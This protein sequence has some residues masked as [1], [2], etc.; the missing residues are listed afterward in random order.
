MR[1]SRH[2]AFVRTALGIAVLLAVALPGRAAVDTLTIGTA[3]QVGSASG[4][5]DDAGVAV[6]VPVFLR[7]SS[8]TALN[9]GT[10]A[11]IQ[12][13][14]FTITFDPAQVYGCTSGN[15]PNCRVS[16]TPAGAFAGHSPVVAKFTKTIHSATVNYEFSRTTDP[17]SFDVDVSSP[18]NLIGYLIIF[19]PQSLT[20]GTTVEL[21][22]DRTANKTFLYEGPDEVVTE[23]EG[24]GLAMVDGAIAISADAKSCTP[25]DIAEL[26]L[27]FLGENGCSP[28][29]ACLVGEKI[30][31][32]LSRFGGFAGCETVRWSFGDGKFE[33]GTVAQHIY[34]TIGSPVVNA[35][36]STPSNATQLTVAEGVDVSGVPGICVPV[37]TA[38]VP[39]TA[40]T[41][42]SINFTGTSSCPGSR[43]AWSFGDGTS[44]AVTGQG[45]TSVV[46]HIYGHA[47]VYPWKLT[48]TGDAEC[49]RSG[50][51]TVSDAPATGRRRPV[52][53]P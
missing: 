8:G 23:T 29:K 39:E 41:G 47:G 46:P 35:T 19:V 2:A 24:S 44:T 1:C 32:T 6:A 31:F 11:Q 34:T 26:S 40:L 27:T 3:Q 25:V 17:L 28:A 45:G 15:L 16:F 20:A 10:D 43:Y 37:C 14:Q 50:T 30:T 4:G 52:R 12:G 13:V 36:V 33:V 7:D 21:T 42:G 48:V 51:I 5:P 49:V 53:S 18:G 38:S 9:S 22:V